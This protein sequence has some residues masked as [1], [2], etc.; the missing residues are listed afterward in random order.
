ME[1]TTKTRGERNNNPFNLKKNS[2]I[3]WLGQ[4]D[5]ETENIFCVFTESSFGLRAGFINLKNQLKEGFNTITKLIT[6]YAP[7]SDA[8]NTEAYIASVAF[9]TKK[10]PNDLLSTADLPMLGK[11]II[12]HEQG[13]CIYTDELL[14]SALIAAGVNLDAPIAFNFS[15]IFSKLRNLF[16]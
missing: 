9:Y 8:N 7:A 13:R 10:R 4:T 6:R 3:N 14:N 2:A 15:D 16:S 5:S 1:Q 12:I 11:S